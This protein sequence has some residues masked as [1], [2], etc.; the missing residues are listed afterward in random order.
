MS[1][2]GKLL[3]LKRKARI[4]QKLDNVEKNQLN[5]QATVH[6]GNTGINVKKNF[7]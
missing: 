4:K 2:N 1:Q 6:D 3:N 5:V 7:F